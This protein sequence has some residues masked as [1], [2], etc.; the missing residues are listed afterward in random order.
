MRRRSKHTPEPIDPMFIAM[1]D[2]IVRRSTIGR[3]WF[4]YNRKCVAFFHAP[5]RT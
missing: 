5:E 4:F 1:A 2:K 3:R